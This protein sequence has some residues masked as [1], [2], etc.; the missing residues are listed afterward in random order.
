MFILSL[1]K[2]Q[3]I[4]FTFL[5]SSSAHYFLFVLCYTGTS[6]GLPLSDID[7]L[8]SIDGMKVA[9]VSIQ[10]KNIISLAIWIILCNIQQTFVHVPAHHW[11]NRSLFDNKTGGNVAASSAVQSRYRVCYHI[12]GSVIQ[13]RKFP[14]GLGAIF[15]IKYE[16]SLCCFG[17][18]FKSLWIF[19]QISIQAIANAI[20]VPVWVERQNIDLKICMYDRLYQ[21]TIIVNSR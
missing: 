15:K 9:G 6:S 18:Y 11:W 20:D 13:Q 1:L 7:D 5:I 14:D 8:S 3:Y 4:E 12:W 2:K 17:L 10:F 21:D 19:Q 16:I